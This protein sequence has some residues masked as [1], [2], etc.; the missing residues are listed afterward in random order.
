MVSSEPFRAQHR[1]HE[2]DERRHAQE[3]RQQCHG[4]TYTFSHKTMKACIAPNASSP[5][6]IIPTVSIDR[7]RFYRA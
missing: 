1:V 2:V 3:Q 7:T 6:T 5:S 4:L